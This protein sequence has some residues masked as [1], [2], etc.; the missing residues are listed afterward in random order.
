MPTKKRATY[1][2]VLALVWLVACGDSPTEPHSRATFP[3]A[4]WVV[5]TPAREGMDAATLD[6]ARAYAF[7]S[8]RYTQG[9]VV[10]RNGVIVGEW[11][12]PG[13]DATSDAT[14]WS[15][16]KSFASTLIGIAIDRGEIAGLDTPLSTWFPSWAGTANAPITVRPLLEMRSGLPWDVTGLSDVDLTLYDGDRLAFSLNRTAASAPGTVWHYSSGDSMLMAGI[17]ES[18]TGMD[19]E[20]YAQARLF[21]PIGMNVHWWKD[22]AGHTMTYCCI[23]TTPRDFARFGLLMAR[24]GVWNGQRIVSESWI[25]A[26]TTPIAEMPS[27]ALQWWTIPGTITVNGAP[28]HCFYADGKDTQRIF[29]VPELDLVVVR[30]GIYN[31]VGTGYVFGSAGFILTTPPATWSDIDF[32]TPVLRAIDPAA[33]YTP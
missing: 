2:V 24:G 13:Y 4:E 22:T 25:T 8:T 21:G 23:D 14:S 30:S 6:Q 1:S 19:V 26:A 5:S 17:L 18:A 20:A 31:L 9:L 32:L 7:D 11:Y 3:G 15:M 27:Y 28:V 33:Q 16:A 10:V 29:V 12:D